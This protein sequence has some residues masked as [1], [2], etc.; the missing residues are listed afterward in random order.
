MATLTPGHTPTAGRLKRQWRQQGRYVSLSLSLFSSLQDV[1]VCVSQQ[2]ADL[3]GADPREI[4][5]TS[6]ATESNNMAIKVH[7][8][9][10]K[11]VFKVSDSAHRVWLDSTR[12]RNLT[13]LLHRL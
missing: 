6:G 13:S 9:T 1:Y 3:I 4:V 12:P 5:F 8:T 11:W 7:Y 2:V 10:D